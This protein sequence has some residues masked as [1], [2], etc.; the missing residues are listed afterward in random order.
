MSLLH[1]FLLWGLAAIAVPILIH[2]LLRDRPKPRPWA[3]MRWLLAA[4]QAAARRW[5]LTNWLLLLLRCLIIALLALAVA[6]PALPGIGGGGHVVLM[7]DCSASMGAR[8]DDPG[9]LAQAQAT[10]AAAVH[11]GGEMPYA[12]WTLV[13][14]ADTVDV[15]ANGDRATVLEALSRLSASALPGGLDNAAAG[16]NAERLA[17]AVESGCD[18]LLISDFQQDDGGRL[19]ALCER[20][21]RRTARWAVGAAS[22]NRW[23]SGPADAGDLRPGEGGDVL[24]HVSGAA[25]GLRLGID[26]GPLV[27]VTGKA[28]G[29]FRLPLPP[30]AAGEHQLRIQLEN[31]GLAYD[32]ILELPIKVRPPLSALVVADRSDYVGAA[33]LADDNGLAATRIRPGVFAGT[34]L[35]SGGAVL[36]RTPIADAQRL[37]MWVRGG[38]VL[39]APLDLLLADPALAQLVIGVAHRDGDVPG[40][41]YASG[42]PDI[43]EV[44]GAAKRERVRATQLPSSARVLLRAGSSPVI[45]SVPA[46]RGW[47]VCELDDIEH[48]A[49]LAGRGT[50]PLWVVRVVRRLAAIAESPSFWVAGQPAPAAATLIRGG[51]HVAIAAGAPLLVA[52]GAWSDAGRTVVVLPNPDEARTDVAAPASAV[53]SLAQALPARPA[54]DLGL[55]LLLLAALV[56]CAEMALAAWAGRTYGG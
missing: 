35:P 42:E 51:A 18:A 48:D 23:I 13:T 30:L 14:V 21:A 37:A 40:G 45:A 31:G 32:D 50:A 8:G 49:A 44:L 2:L 55:W 20:S 6:R 9:P 4:Y 17:S 52:P 16:S 29:S 33:L 3:A 41:M 36:L 39:W 53:T 22:P 43:D 7:V 28:T 19:V 5:K 12:R 34:A 47:V 15:V 26:G 24:M 46:G 54:L 1:P 10:L 25:A 11:N 27:Q 38:G 56:A